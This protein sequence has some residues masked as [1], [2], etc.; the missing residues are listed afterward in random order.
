MPVKI[1]NLMHPF[2]KASSFSPI[3]ISILPCNGLAV[4]GANGS[5]K[6]TF[7]RIL[8][9]EIHPTKG[10]ISISERLTYLGV[11]NG[12]KPQLR[13]SHQLPYFTSNYDSFP[14]PELFKKKYKDL[15]LG[16][17]RLTALWISLHSNRSIV[18]LDEPFIHL[19]F[20]NFSLACTWIINQLNCGKIIILTHHNPTE[21]QAIYP[22]QILDLNIF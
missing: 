1:L 11:K 12:L 4:C 21:L 16:Y 15:S 3:N 2:I 17:Q 9:E 14:W 6:T 19:D 5:G 10:S 8:L 22:L 20:Q 18:L 7:L 13:L